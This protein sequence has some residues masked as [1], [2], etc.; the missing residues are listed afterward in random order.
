MQERFAD[1]AQD[2]YK[3]TYVGD[4]IIQ[5][6]DEKGPYVSGTIKTD[7]K[8][9]ITATNIENGV[10]LG[11]PGIKTITNFNSSPKTFKFI[12]EQVTDESG[13]DK[14]AD[15]KY[16]EATFTFGEDGKASGPFSFTLNYP[17]GELP[18]SLP[19]KMYFKII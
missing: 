7:A 13:A 6:T 16:Q 14:V 11:I 8:V 2:D 3:V 17:A 1:S 12:L 5:N 19:T 4:D 15:G 9:S 10:S 18:R